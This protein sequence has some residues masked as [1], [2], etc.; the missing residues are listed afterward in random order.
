[1]NGHHRRLPAM[2]CAIGLGLA[3]CS[4]P[5]PTP[6]PTPTPAPAPKAFAGT[7]GA[8]LNENKR[9]MD[10]MMMDMDVA[11]TGDVDRDF[12][13]MMIPH[14]QGGIDMA[15]AL[16]RHGK[17]P[18]LRALAQAIVTKQQEEI[19]L[20]RQILGDGAATAEQAAPAMDGHDIH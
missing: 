14:H 9:A 1:M 8:F 10:H 12:A 3:A 4:K 6:V 7:E 17:N 13:R 19:V 11:P 15:Q 18:R 16:L 5:A 20:M 2:L